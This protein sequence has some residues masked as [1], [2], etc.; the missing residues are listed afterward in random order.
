VETS[1]NTPPLKVVIAGGGVA[2]LEATLALR[3]LAGERVSVTIVAPDSEFVYRPMRVREP[4][5]LSAARRYSL[6]EFARDTGAELVRDS[7]KWLDP[8]ARTLYT[9]TGAQLTYDALLLAMGARLNARFKH[10]ITLDDRH[11]DEQLHG[12]IQDIEGGYT[13]SLAFVIPYP[14]PWP[15]PVYELA[16]MTAG[17]AEDMN[18]DL[19][20]TI[21][22]PEDAPLALFGAPVSE[23]VQS[24]LE[25]HGIL[26]ITSAHCEVPEPG[27][28]MI[29]PG[30]RRLHVDR[31]VAAP[32]LF[33]PSTPGVPKGAPD[34]F[35]P[36]DAHCRVRGLEGVYAAGD[37]TDF[38]VKLGA[39]AAQQADTAAEAIAALAGAQV[40]PKPFHPTV[41]AIL[42]GGEKPLYLSAQITGGHGSSSEI[43][44]TPTWSPVSKISARYLAPYL[45]ARDRAL[46]SAG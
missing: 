12:L 25:R 40:E 33:G 9:E 11:L 6:E 35:I 28:V 14:M 46:P 4:F 39:I 23:A 27:Q 17:R 24:L 22:T 21:A 31:I 29:H 3:D 43:S 16:L 26:T 5:G 32:Q 1:S 13:H 45:D 7:F 19:S 38:A 41:H 10:A 44:E 37:A 36:V 30:Q 42:L 8:A 18:V 20:I 15:L 34:G 2:A